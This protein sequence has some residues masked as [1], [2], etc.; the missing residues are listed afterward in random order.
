MYT[1]VCSSA[2]LISVPNILSNNIDLPEPFF[3][4]HTQNMDEGSSQNL[5]H[6]AEPYTSACMLMEAFAL[7]HK[8]QNI[9]C[10]YPN[11]E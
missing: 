9:L 11:N 2:Y 1:S 10:I 4:L 8:Y 3:C 6:L 5:E 7:C